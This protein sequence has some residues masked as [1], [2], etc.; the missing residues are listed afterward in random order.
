[1]HC[2]TLPAAMGFSRVA[3]ALGG[4]K[5]GEPAMW[6]GSLLSHTQNSLRVRLMLTTGYT[7]NALMRRT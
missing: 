1:M 3:Q 4:K 7:G 2:A 5:G 6:R